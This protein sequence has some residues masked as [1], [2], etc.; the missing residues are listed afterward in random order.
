MDVDAALERA[1][2]LVSDYGADHSSIEAIGAW[3]CHPVGGCTCGSEGMSHMSGC[4]HEPITKLNSV[5]G[6]SA[7]A[8]AL[9]SS[10][11]SRKGIPEYLKL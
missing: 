8:N 7:V 11:P 3:V 4:G 5:E 2:K 1:R 6:A 9:T 10:P